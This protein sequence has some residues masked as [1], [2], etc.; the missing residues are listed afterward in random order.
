[1]TRGERN[2]NPGNIRRV[3][4]VHWQGESPVQSDDAFVTFAA[5]EFGFRAIAR[6]L[7]SYQKR[8]LC[9]INQIINRWAPP[10]EN[11]SVAYVNHVA[12][13]CGVDPDEILDLGTFLPKIIHAIT[14][15][16]N[17]VFNYTEQQIQAGI[18]LA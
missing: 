9:T 17:G 6:I 18:S 3:P 5:P 16:E 11:D 15:H 8:G 1:M 7:R 14:V 13:Y 10:N 2:H 4:G 12:E